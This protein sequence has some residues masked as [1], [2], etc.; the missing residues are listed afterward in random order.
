MSKTVNIALIDDHRMFLDGL[1]EV[2]NS[3]SA[4]YKCQSYASPRHAISEIEDGRVF[5]LIVSDFVM[6]EMNGIA[7]ILALKARQCDVPVLIVSGIDTLPPV[8]KVLQNGAMGF[9]PKSAPTEILAT[10]ISTALRGD[11]YLPTELWSVME[12]NPT[13]RHVPV[14]QAGSEDADLIGPRQI[15]VLKLV[16]EGYSNKR[17]SD[18]L[19]ISENTVKTHIKQIFRQLN[20]TRRTACVSKAQ[21][22]GLLD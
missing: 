5:D 10:A 9:V 3:L 7:L 14:P 2:I 11:I 18:V 12:K 6:E 20:V 13:S 16:A 1:R 22:L 15:E 8:E 4:D 19:A 21:A 17:I